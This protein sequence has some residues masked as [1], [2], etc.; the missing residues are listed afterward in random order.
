[1]KTYFQFHEDM[2]LDGETLDSLAKSLSGKE[3]T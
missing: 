1:M 3:S 2:V